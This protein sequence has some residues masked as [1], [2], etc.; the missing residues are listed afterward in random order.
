MRAGAIDRIGPA[1]QGDTPMIARVLS[2]TT[3]AAL[4][5]ATV[6]T[7]SV[8]AAEARGRAWAGAGVGL[9]AGLIAGGIIASQSRPAYAAPHYYAPPPRRVCD[10]RWVRDDYGYRH[11]E[12]VCWY[13]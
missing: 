10:W 9:A 8:D 1:S 11:R 6:L 2:K 4:A 7:F 5:V 3:A 13:R 12:R